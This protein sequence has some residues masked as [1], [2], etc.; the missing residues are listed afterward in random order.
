MGELEPVCD[1]FSITSEFV[2]P[3]AMAQTCLRRLCGAG[4]VEI[5]VIF[6]VNNRRTLT[7]RE[8]NC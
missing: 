4:P 8:Y 6:T 1:L 7:L 5:V 2:S 3:E